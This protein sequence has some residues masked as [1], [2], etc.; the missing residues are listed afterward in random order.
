M[1][2]V[3]IAGLALGLAS[4][5][6]YSSSS[7]PAELPPQD[8][9]STTT[10]QPSTTGAYEIEMPSSTPAADIPS[11]TTQ[12]AYGNYGEEMS[13]RYEKMRRTQTQMKE[14]QHSGGRCAIDHSLDDH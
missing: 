4:A 6:P 11:T 5:A 3:L 9:P 1:H 14:F 2:L 13:T 7:P 8:V 10:L 12:Q